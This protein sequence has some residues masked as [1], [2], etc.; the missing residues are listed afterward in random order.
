[1]TT[2][3]I[4]NASDARFVPDDRYGEPVDGMWWC[5]IS[6]DT[7]TGL[8]SFLLRMDPGTSSKPHE[9]MDYE[10]FFV[11]DGELVDNDGAVFRT[12]D[13]VSFRPG[14]KHWSTTDQG[15]TLA[16]FLRQ[17]NRRLNDEERRNLE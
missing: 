14:S 12:G 10:E 5:N 6:Y 11:I 8:G 4:L 2:R 7:A 15:C 3:Q 9:H 16:V 1:M 17:A 13:F